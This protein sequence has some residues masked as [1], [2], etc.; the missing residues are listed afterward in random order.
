MPWSSRLLRSG[1]YKLSWC[2][3]SLLLFRAR[4]GAALEQKVSKGTADVGAAMKS[5]AKNSAIG[6]LTIQCGQLLSTRI[7]HYAGVFRTVESRRQ[8]GERDSQPIYHRRD[9]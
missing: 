3:Y 9:S 6:F 1:V 5:G 8:S 7:S 4:Q 2:R